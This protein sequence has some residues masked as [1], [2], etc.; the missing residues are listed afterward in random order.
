MRVATAGKELFGKR[1]GGKFRTRRLAH[2]V[3]RASSGRQ[4]PRSFKGLHRPQRRRACQYEV[5]LGLALAS[6]GMIGRILRQSATEICGQG[7]GF[8]SRRRLWRFGSRTEEAGGQE[9]VERE[10]VAF[11]ALQ[12]IV[13]L[14]VDVGKSRAAHARRQRQNGDFARG[15]LLRDGSR[16]NNP[17]IEAVRNPVVPGA[18]P[19]FGAGISELLPP[20]DLSFQPLPS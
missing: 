18:R 2:G 17:V 10:V 20:S 6:K 15:E 11:G 9:G 16:L 14:I 13:A 7:Q 5:T 8:A 19:G 1:D 3:E 12:G 4:D